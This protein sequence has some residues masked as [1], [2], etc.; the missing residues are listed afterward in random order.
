M[1][2]RA[3]HP[4]TRG[5]L[6]AACVIVLC[7]VAA[8]SAAAF[9]GERQTVACKTISAAEALEALED[10][11]EVFAG[12]GQDTP[13]TQVHGVRR[14]KGREI[15]CTWATRHTQGY[16]NV[17][18]NVLPTASEAKRYFDARGLCFHRPRLVVGA[19]GCGGDQDV[20]AR[21]G[22]FAITVDGAS[23][24]DGTVMEARHLVMVAK[25]VFSRAPRVFAGR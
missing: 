4:C 1:T 5:V 18:V 20:Y 23:A 13:I 12:W 3:L 11:G 17:F 2:R 24:K 9:R 16:I 19:A 22:R 6:A 8:A 14:F 21:W 7:A 10:T 15:D 25:A